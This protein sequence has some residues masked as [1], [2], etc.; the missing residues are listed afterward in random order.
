MG[1]NFPAFITERWEKTESLIE[2]RDVET[3]KNYIRPEGLLYL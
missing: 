2:K 3:K 1:N